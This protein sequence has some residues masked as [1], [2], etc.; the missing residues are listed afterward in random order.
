ADRFSNDIK[1]MIGY[2][3]LCSFRLCWRY[4]TPAV[5]IQTLIDRQHPLIRLCVCSGH[6]RLLAHLLVSA[7]PRQWRDGPRMGYG[8]GLDADAVLCVPPAALGHLQ[9]REHTGNPSA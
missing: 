7:D 9:P 2:Q 5:C 6:V 1:A 3:P 4:L 8:D